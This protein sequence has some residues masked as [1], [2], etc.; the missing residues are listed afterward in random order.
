[1]R[2]EKLE[3]GF[4]FPSFPWRLMEDRDESGMDS[5]GGKGGV[6]VGGGGSCRLIDL[7]VTAIYLA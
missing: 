1:M 6:E 7:A 5:R 4:R 3:A 2:C